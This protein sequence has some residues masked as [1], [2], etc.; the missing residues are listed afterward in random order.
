MYVVAGVTGNTGKAVAETLLARRKPVRA[1]PFELH[2]D[3]ER[4]RYGATI[5][6]DGGSLL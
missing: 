3:G 5:P 6:V 2:E 4:T 1:L